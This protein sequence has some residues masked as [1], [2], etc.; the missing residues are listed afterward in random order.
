[1]LD[2]KIQV[3]DFL[4]CC[5]DRKV[6]SEKTTTQIYTHVAMTKQKEILSATHPLNKINL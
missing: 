2:F 6:L 3:S 1:M 5:K 4:C